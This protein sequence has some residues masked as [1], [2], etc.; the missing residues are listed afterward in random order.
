MGEVGCSVN[1]SCLGARMYNPTM[2]I[3]TNI[4]QGLWILL[5]SFEEC[6]F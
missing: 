6:Q 1:Y 4:S 3:M 5:Y 2:D